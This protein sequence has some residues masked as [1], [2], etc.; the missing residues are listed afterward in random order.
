[1]PTMYWDDTGA[2]LADGSSW[3]NRASL[4]D[5][6]AGNTSLIAGLSANTYDMRVL[7][8][9]GGEYDVTAAALPFA[10]TMYGGFSA[11]ATNFVRWNA[12]DNTGALW[13]PPRGWKATDPDFDET[14]MV[15]ITSSDNI[16][17]V[18]GT[19][20]NLHGFYGFKFRGTGKTTGAVVGSAQYNWCKIFNEAASTTGGAFSSTDIQA[21]NCVFACTG[22][23]YAY[24][25]NLASALGGMCRNLRIYGAAGSSGNRD[26]IVLV[27]S[28]GNQTLVMTDSCIH[29]VGGRGFFGST[30][31][32]SARVSM[33]N[34]TIAKCNGSGWVASSTATQSTVRTITDSMITDNG[35]YGIDGNAQGHIFAYNVRTDR[36]TTANV[37]YASNSANSPQEYLLTAAGSITDEYV[38]PNNA[39]IAS[40]NFRIKNTSAYW[41]KGLGAGDEAAA[42]GGGG[43]RMFAT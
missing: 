34:M 23:T 15:K 28:A 17:Q 40:R 24:V 27:M 20:A 31:I 10:S 33:Q 26:G 1:M 16:A 11:S 36:N 25:M 19:G 30:D 6:F 42:G 3:A 18:T 8:V 21:R 41:N 2:G 22:A 7:P 13:T 37:N 12:C 39:T 4:P 43:T 38:D 9:S 29:S 32:A 14:G 35:A 5:E